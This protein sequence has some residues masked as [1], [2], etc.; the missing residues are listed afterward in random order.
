M[1]HEGGWPR[2]QPAH[3]AVLAS[4]WGPGDFLMG[5]VRSQ[6]VA[7]HGHSG[8]VTDMDEILWLLVSAAVDLLSHR[9]NPVP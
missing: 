8:A 9:R 2:Q 3:V 5:H 6:G 7:V 4:M 1:L